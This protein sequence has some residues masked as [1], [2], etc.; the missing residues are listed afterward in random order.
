[1][2]FRSE[3]PVFSL[4]HLTFFIPVLGSSAIRGDS[5]PPQVAFPAPDKDVL[6]ASNGS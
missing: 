5:Y 6:F 3:K 1:V 4:A 2:L